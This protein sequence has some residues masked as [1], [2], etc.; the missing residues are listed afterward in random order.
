MDLLKIVLRLQ[1]FCN[2]DLV[3]RVLKLS[4][5]ARRLDVAASPY[6]A[7]EFNVGVI[8]VETEEGRALY[9]KQQ[10]VLME[11]A[12]PIRKELLD[13]YNIFLKLAFDEDPSLLESHVTPS[14]ERF[15]QAQ[16]GGKPWRRNLIPSSTFGQTS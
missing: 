2:P 9:R 11:R 7:T 6:D 12:E 5:D 10:R 15:A 1:P 3:Q 4:L 8:P 13:S 16:P 14:E